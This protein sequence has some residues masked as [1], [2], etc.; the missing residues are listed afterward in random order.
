[1]TDNDPASSTPPP[2]PTPPDE[3]PPGA[4]DARFTLAAER[5][6]LAWLRTALGLIAAGVAVI[7]VVGDF[8]ASGARISLGVALV[9]LGSAT[10]LIGAWRW[11]KV[12]HI[13]ENGG[14]MPGPAAVWAVTIAMV[15]LAVGF[16]VFG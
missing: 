16:V 13:L 5:T 14:K 3:V 9:V 7:H 11:Q 10:A 1:M 8:N 4:A 2:K 12:T 6:M 15:V